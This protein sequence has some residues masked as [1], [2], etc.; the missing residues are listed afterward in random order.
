MKDDRDHL[1]GA[2]LSFV[3][4]TGELPGNRAHGRNLAES[5]PKPTYAEENADSVGGESPPQIA[6]ASG[7]SE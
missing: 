6:L 4:G 5:N 3:I 2:P 7:R 1:E